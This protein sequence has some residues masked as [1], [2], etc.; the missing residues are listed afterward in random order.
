MSNLHRHARKGD[1]DPGFYCGRGDRER[2]SSQTRSWTRHPRQQCD[3]REALPLRIQ[4]S[5]KISP[6][7]LP[8]CPGES[9]RQTTLALENKLSTRIQGRPTT[10]P[11]RGSL[12]VGA[13][14]RLRALQW[15]QCLPENRPAR[16]NP[17]E[18][19][20]IKNSMQNS[21]P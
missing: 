19:F 17:A 7:T 5:M 1:P 21:Q 18:I 4:P 2:D 15:P 20:R 13:S 14:I 12:A 9:R 8:L 10:S 6:P 3:H 16:K 11:A